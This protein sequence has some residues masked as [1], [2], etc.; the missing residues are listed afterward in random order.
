[1]IYHHLGLGDHIFCNGLIRELYK[2]YTTIVFPVK[3][4][5]LNSV[6]IMFSDL[7]INYVIC[8]DDQ[9]MIDL[10][11]NISD[12]FVKLGI[13]FFGYNFDINSHKSFVELF[14]DQAHIDYSKRWSSFFIP[15]F[16]LNNIQHKPK[17]NKY[18]FVHDDIERGYKIQDKYILTGYEVYRPDHT[19][20]KNSENTI[21]DYL[22]IIKNA[23]E[24]HCMDSSFA[25]VIDHYPDLFHKKKFI[26]QYAKK[27]IDPVYFPPDYRNN[28]N[29]LC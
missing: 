28:W 19:L 10:G 12:Q 6:K 3:F 27:D 15:K 1:M 21:F 4:A 16:I 25:A 2:K 11:N 9:Q 23:E 8:N 5:N 20:A 17:S 18:I 22:D 26:H 29:I 14:Y 13:G 24:I 7:N